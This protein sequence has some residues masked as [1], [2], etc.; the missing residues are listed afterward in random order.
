MVADCGMSRYRHELTPCVRS[1]RKQDPVDLKQDANKWGRD[2][3]RARF[4]AKNMRQHVDG[5]SES[6]NEAGSAMPVG[7]HLATR[8]IVDSGS[9]FDLAGSATVRKAGRSMKQVALQKLTV[10]TGRTEI[11]EEASVRV[12]ELGLEAGS[13]HG[14]FTLF[15]LFLGRVCMTQG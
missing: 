15:S 10:A 11:S 13:C 2:A 8:G 14:C 7:T 3:R 9:C 1:T 12:G 6:R 5:K 4:R